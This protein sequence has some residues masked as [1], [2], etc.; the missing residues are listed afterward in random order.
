MKVAL[1]KVAGAGGALPAQ[2]KVEEFITKHCFP[3]VNMKNIDRFLDTLD[4]P[5]LQDLIQKASARLVKKNETLAAALKTALASHGE[6]LQSAEE[7]M[8]SLQEHMRTL[9]QKH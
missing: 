2:V 6:I 4:G 1:D 8:R 9:E 5:D 3:L 7:H